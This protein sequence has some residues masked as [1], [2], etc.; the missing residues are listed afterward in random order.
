MLV[1]VP[2]PG[3]WEKPAVFNFRDRRGKGLSEIFADFSQENLPGDRFGQVVGAAAGQAL[4]AVFGHGVRG[5]GDDR[6][7]EP[8][9]AQFRGGGVAVHHRHLHVHQDQVERLRRRQVDRDCGRS[10]RSRPSAP[11]IRRCVESSRWLSRP[12]SASRMRP[13]NGMSVRARGDRSVRR[14]ARFGQLVDH[15]DA[16][17]GPA[18][19]PQREGA[20]DSRLGCNADVA[21]EQSG[22]LP[23][24]RQAQAGAAEPAGGGFIG[25]A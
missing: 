3:D 7:R 12:S 25:L 9:A 18:V 5:E 20:S 19:D 17:A 13:R 8:A 6:E 16:A 24:D 15:L 22:K 11:A 4:L 1:I 14:Q 10:R 2:S 23:A 21:A